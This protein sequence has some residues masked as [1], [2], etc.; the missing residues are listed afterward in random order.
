MITSAGVAVPD[1]MAAVLADD[2]E[3]QTI[4][5]SLRH[6]DQLAYVNWLA[7]PGA[8][9]RK[10]R[11]AELAGHVRNHKFRSRAAG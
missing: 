10:E 6:D 8:Q 11:L 2:S 3:A 4:F 1:D 9:S 5:E 7:K